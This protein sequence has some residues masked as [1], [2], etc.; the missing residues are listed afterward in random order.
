MRFDDPL[1]SISLI[2][3]LK[4]E[5]PSKTPILDLLRKTVPREWFGEHF[6]QLIMRTYVKHP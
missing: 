2:R 3:P 4:M 5:D 1:G 6:I